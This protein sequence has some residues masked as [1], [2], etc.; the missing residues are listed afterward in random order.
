MNIQPQ[1]MHN[2]RFITPAEATIPVFT[3]ALVGSFGVYETILARHGKYV[4]LVEHLERLAIS[5]Q[6]AQLHLAADIDTLKRWCYLLLAANRPD[7]LVR[8]LV[9]D[10]GEPRAD[11]FLYQATYS[12]PSSADY[13]HGVAV[14]VF[15]GERALPNVKSFNTLVPGLARKAAVAAGVHDALM[16]DRDGNITEGSNCNVFA[17]IDGELVVPPPEAILAGTVMERVIR[18]AVEIDIP[19]LRRPL[20]L[21]GVTGWRE[22]FLT[23]T[24]RGVLPI[25]RVGEHSLGD[26]GPVTK[27]LHEAYAAWEET[28]LSS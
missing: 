22:A 9:L 26:P 10:L 1:I 8:V 25:N 7:G 12:P 15:H 28:A 19:V 23:S 21:S 20:P 2:G 24:R 5:A 13:E 16:V 14:A 3:P 11:V 4:A 27:R 6:G 17:V 18:L